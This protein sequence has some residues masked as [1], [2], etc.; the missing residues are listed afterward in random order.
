MSGQLLQLGANLGIGECQFSRAFS[1][2]PAAPRLTIKV[3]PV[4]NVAAWLVSQKAWPTATPPGTPVF[5]YTLVNSTDPNAAVNILRSGS[6]LPPAGGTPLGPGEPDVIVASADR[7]TI[8]IDARVVDATLSADAGG[9]IEVEVHALYN[10]PQ[11]PAPL[12]PNCNV[13][14][15][16]RRKC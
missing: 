4:P 5:I 3:P 14:P 8:T 2:T 13:P 9:T 11:C 15:A 7:D 1:P 12:D 6:V 10:T 16:K